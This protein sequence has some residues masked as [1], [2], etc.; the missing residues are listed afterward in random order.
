ML[1][2]TRDLRWIAGALIVGAISFNAVLCFLNTRGVAISN[3][4]VIL[5]ETLL[6]S[7]AL[8]ASRDYI[9]I[10]HL[11]TITIIIV[12][13]LAL[14]I[15]RCSNA[16]FDPKICRDLVIPVIFFL[17]GKAVNDVRAADKVVFTATFIVLGFAIFEYFFLETFL[18]VFGVAEYYIARGTLRELGG[19]AQRCPRTHDQWCPSRRPRPHTVGVPWRPSR[20][21][22]FS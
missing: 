12:Y 3:V 11:F 7:M 18:K 19:R 16:A 15:I 14:S 17:L 2:D 13:T 5:S 21:V 22:N 6:I 10:T 1:A 4:H 20:I 8:L 9:K